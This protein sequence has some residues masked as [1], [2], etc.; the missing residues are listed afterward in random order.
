MIMG[1]IRGN[2]IQ[3][4]LLMRGLRGCGEAGFQETK[5]ALLQQIVFWRAVM[6]YAHSRGMTFYFF[7]WNIYVD[8]A[9]TQYPALTTIASNTNTIN[10]MY[11]GE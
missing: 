6:Q 2:P 9:S 7:D 4:V 11:S 1:E 5:V 10:Y 8:Y 3:I